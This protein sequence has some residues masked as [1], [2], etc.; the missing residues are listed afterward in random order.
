MT[1]LKTRIDDEAILLT[2]CKQFL[3]EWDGWDRNKSHEPIYQS[4]SKLR[5]VTSAVEA[6]RMPVGVIDMNRDDPGFLIIKFVFMGGFL[7][8][9]FMILAKWLHP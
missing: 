8:T 7:A 5:K 4:L 1:S 3:A 6:K 2:A 9:W